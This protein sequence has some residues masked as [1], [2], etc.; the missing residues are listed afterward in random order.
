[1]PISLNPRIF[2]PD[3]EEQAVRPTL[4][5]AM[6]PNELEAAAWKVLKEFNR[7]PRVFVHAGTGQLVRVIH[8][9]EGGVHIEPLSRDGLRALLTEAAIWRKGARGRGSYPPESMIKNM[10]SRR[11]APLPVLRRVAGFPFF[12]SSGELVFRAGY[13]GQNRVY[14]AT[15]YTDVWS[16]ARKLARLPEVALLEILIE[17]FRDFPFEDDSSNA[18]LFCLM[19]TPLLRELFRGPVPLFCVNKPAPGLGGTLLVQTAA[20]ILTGGPLPVIPPPN[21]NDGAELRRLLTS[22]LRDQPPCLVLDNWDDLASPSLAAILTAETYTDRLIGRSTIFTSENTATIVVV[23]NNVR[24]GPEISRRIVPI[25]LAPRG[26]DPRTRTDFRIFDLPGWTRRH[27]TRLLAALLALVLRWQKAGRP[28]SARRLPSFERWSAIVGGILEV[29]GVNG[30]LGNVDRE[31]TQA[32]EMW[33]TFLRSWHERFGRRPVQACELVE[34]ARES[35]V[36]EGRQTPVS[37]GRILSARA[38]NVF[39]PFQLIRMGRSDNTGVYRLEYLT[40]PD[41]STGQQAVPES[42]DGGITH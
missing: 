33:L 3:P 38:G 21:R 23:G 26:P 35:G 18:H 41:R 42:N 6:L 14:L 28:E 22:A 36:A 1:M 4:D 9:A 20:T 39:G 32:S 31:T 8:T 16:V 34:L 13:D 10:S 37:L 12:G 2:E 40:A 7:P 19:L 17:P 5:L 29:N 30:F 25:H 15:D 27:R 24:L 11:N